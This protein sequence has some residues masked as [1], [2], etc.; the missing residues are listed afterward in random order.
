MET[1]AIHPKNKE[2]LNA[3]KALLK[4]FK[5]PFEKFEPYDPNFVEKIKVSEK[6]ESRAVVLK[7]DKDID[8]FFTNL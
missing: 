2:Q 6:N 8:D 3:L 7:S 1:I 5:I 4:D